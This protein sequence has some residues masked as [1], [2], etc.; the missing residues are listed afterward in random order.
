MQKSGEAPSRH[1][2]RN[3]LP[4]SGGEAGSC[5]PCVLGARREPASGVQHSG[6]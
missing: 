4:G 2:L 3:Y 6:D 5:G 1:L